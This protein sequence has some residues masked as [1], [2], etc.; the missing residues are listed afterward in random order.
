MN[1]TEREKEIVVVR[2]GR[3]IRK[4]EKSKEPSGEIKEM[5]KK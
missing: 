3:K 5:R 4:C 2:R 1:D